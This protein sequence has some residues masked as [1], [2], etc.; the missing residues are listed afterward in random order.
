MSVKIKQIKKTNG[1]NKNS[2]EEISI[3][4]NQMFGDDPVYDPEI[5]YYKCIDLE[6]YLNLFK[7]IIE[8]FYNFEMIKD[9]C[10]ENIQLTDDYYK[11]EEFL[12]DFDLFLKTKVKLEYTLDD[13]R[14]KNFTVE[15][16]SNNLYDPKMSKN[17]TNYYNSIKKSEYINVIMETLKKLQIHKKYLQD[18]KFICNFINDIPGST[19]ELF[20]FSSLNIKFIYNYQFSDKLDNT[21]LKKFISSIFKK[22]FKCCVC[23]YDTITDVDFDITRFTNIIID[24]IDNLKKELPRCN[25]AFDVISNSLNKINTNFKKYYKYFESTNDPSIIIESFI[26]DIYEDNKSD[27]VLINQLKKIISYFSN[28]IKTNTKTPQN[29]SFL[30]DNLNDISNSTNNIKQEDD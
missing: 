25:E 16:L 17:L 3:L 2:I 29:V 13:I 10:I 30:I 15:D 5:I 12:K 28:K 14:K 11:I 9:I 26:K 23:I 7:K 21:Q 27:P 18:D 24:N 4:F 19:Y 22:L 20:S 1:V 6:K 8:I